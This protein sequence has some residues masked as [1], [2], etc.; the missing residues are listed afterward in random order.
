LF[1][2]AVSAWQSESLIFCDWLR[3]DGNYGIFDSQNEADTC[4]LYCKNSV[5]SF[6][7]N[8]SKKLKVLIWH[9]GRRGG[10]P[11]YTFELAR[12]LKGRADTEIVVSISKQCEIYDEF[13]SLGVPLMAVNTYTGIASAIAGSFRLPMLRHWF[14]RFV[15]EQKVDLVIGTM[16]HIWNSVVLTGSSDV[17]YLLVLHDAT[18]HPGEESFLLRWL[19]TREISKS[20]AIVTLT[21]YVRRDLCLSYAY[22]KSKTW[23]IPHGVFPYI[24]V[25]GRIQSAGVLRLLFFGR[26]LRY[27]GLSVLLE[28]Y[29]EVRR[30]GLDVSLHIA[31]PGDMTPYEKRIKEIQG[32]TIDN[33]WIP[34]DA[35]ADIF[36]T[37][38][39]TVIPYLEA[40]QSG[41]V[42]TSFAA[43]VPVMVTPVGGLVEQVSDGENGLVCRSSQVND[44]AYSISRFAKDDTLR[45]RCTIGARR[46]AEHDLAWPAIAEKFSLVAHQMCDAPAI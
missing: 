17:P 18:Q 40:S 15:R 28:A 21:E 22:P 2:V 35:I 31:G 39:L 25:G 26:I 46:T 16:S 4:F 12:A 32:I 45:V 20:R 3:D 7:M 41:V 5:G 36:A 13:S 24:P 19:L 11:R 43:G 6:L 27:K 9:W 1:C 29:A 37:A 38:D 42:A 10:G 23:V 34:E 30:Q 8:K 14:W 33:R 44:V